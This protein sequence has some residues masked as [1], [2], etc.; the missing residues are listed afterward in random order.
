MVQQPL[1]LSGEGVRK[2]PKK[3]LKPVLNVAFLIVVFVATI[4][5]VLGGE[6]LQQLWT[7]MTSADPRWVLPAIGL[8]VL[9]IVG[10]SVVIHLLLRTLG[11]VVRFGHCCLYSFVGFF[12]SCITPSASGGQPMQIVQMRRDGIPTAVATVVLGIVTITYKL[13]LVF[14]GLAVMLISPEPLMEYLE[15]ARLLVWLGLALNTGWVSVLMML[16]FS[17]VAVRKLSVKTLAL[18]GRIRPFKHP[19]RIEQRLEHAVDQYAGTAE[20]FLSHKLLMIRVFL[21]TLVQRLVLFTVPYF[22][23]RAFHLSGESLINILLLQAMISV[24]VDMLP[25]PGGMGITENLFLNLFKPVFG[26][27]LVLPAMVVSRGISYYT[28]LL[29]SAVMTLAAMFILREKKR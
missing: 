25:F 9:F 4:W 11:T 3:W 22:I 15:S 21:I 26:A 19:E 8:V 29:L 6:N 14:I 7:H 16:V 28:Q 2:L 24:A 20:Y 5:A 17:P 23:Y 10:E 13:V 27:V 1:L 12:Y 18:L